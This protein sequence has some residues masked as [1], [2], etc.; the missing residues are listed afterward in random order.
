[1]Y[2]R[3]PGIRMGFVEFA[4]E[5]HKRRFT[6]RHGGVVLLI[7]IRDNADGIVSVVL[8]EEFLVKI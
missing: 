2:Y 5:F 4:K 6:I 8:I 1:M 3:R 7:A